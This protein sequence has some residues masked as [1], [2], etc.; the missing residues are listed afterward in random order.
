MHSINSNV[1]FSLEG[2][3]PQFYLICQRNFPGTSL[4]PAAKMRLVLF[5]QNTSAMASSERRYFD[6]RFEDYD[7]RTSLQSP[8]GKVRGYCENQDN[9]SLQK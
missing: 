4:N 8:D 9:Q 3:S 2:I 1:Y 7:G 6:N 5:S